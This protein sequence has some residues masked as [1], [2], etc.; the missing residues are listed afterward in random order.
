MT[1]ESKDTPVTFELVGVMSS[2]QQVEVRAR[3]D[4]FLD[5]RLYTE[6]D[7][8]KQGQVMF[9]MDA[10]PFQAQL[11][12]AQSA[13]AEQQARLWTAQANLKRVRPLAK[14]N[15]LSKKELDDAQG[16][17]NADAAAV[18]MARADVETAKLNLSYT[19]IEAPVTGASSFAR[20]QNGAY[21]NALSGPL[22]YVAQ[23]DP[24]WVD[25]SLSEDEFL[26]FRQEEK[27]GQLL[28]PENSALVVELVLS[29]GSLY[30]ETGRIFF[31]DANYNTETGTF[32]IRATFSNPDGDLRP[33]QF[34]RVRLKGVTRPNAILVPQQAVLQGAQ[35]FFVWI[36]D[37]DGKAQVR[38]VEAGDWQDDNWFINKGL[39]PGDRVITD[40]IVRLAKGIPVK[41]VEQG[42]DEPDNAAT[43]TDSTVP[44]KAGTTS[45]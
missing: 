34:V 11:D 20:I 40:G 10:R 19:T 16:R 12:A 2:S 6:G 45:D 26:K 14:A 29:D 36:V 9:K 15:A 13:L 30:P 39:S 38:N 35:G 28:A 8:V 31:R 18:D 32:L 23:L 25:F 17:V 27:S 7:I 4:G 37:A 1:V 5:D 24:I 3:V 43:G 44:D 41:I 22:T 21:I 42:M 33:G